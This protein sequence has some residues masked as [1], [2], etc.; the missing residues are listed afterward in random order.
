MTMLKTLMIAGVFM[1]PLLVLQFS[2]AQ[3]EDDKAVIPALILPDV[4]DGLYYQQDELIAHVDQR[5]ALHVDET[6]TATDL[7]GMDREEP[8]GNPPFRH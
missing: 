4:Q 5:I 3:A 6:F 8:V 2:S 7:S 1:V